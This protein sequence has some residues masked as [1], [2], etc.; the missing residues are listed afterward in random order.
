MRL[1]F[2]LLLLMV[3]ALGCAS[4]YVRNGLRSEAGRKR[5]LPLLRPLMRVI[6]PRVVRAVERR[7]SDFGVIHHIGRRSGA[8]YHTPVDVARTSEGVLICLPYGPETDWCRN[9]LAAQRCTLT[10]DGDELALTAPEV[11]L[12]PAV[13]QQLTPEK[14]RQWEREGI[15]HCL[16]LK[17]VPSKTSALDDLRSTGQPSSAVG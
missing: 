14:L 16:S 15:A 3:L 2:G 17:H 1:A 11:V 4:V 8:S 6:N 7:Q 5:L 10:V 13:E 12:A 9:V